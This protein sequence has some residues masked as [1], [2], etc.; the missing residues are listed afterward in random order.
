MG[1]GETQLASGTI[2]G[3]RVAEKG[4]VLNVNVP[5]AFLAAMQRAFWALNVSLW[6]KRFLK[7]LRASVCG[8]HPLVSATK[9][10]KSRD[11]IVIAICVSN[12]ASQSSSDLRHV[13]HP[14]K[15]QCGDLMH[16]DGRC[17]CDPK[18]V[19]TESSNHKWRGSDLQFD[20]YRTAVQR[21]FL[22]VGLRNFK[23]LAIGNL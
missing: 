16:R 17:E 11:L 10:S 9:C 20:P 23:S 21:N 5:L 3:Q 8:I 4:Y 22:R 13:N 15:A 1:Q 19:R 7:S 12:R 6:V 2:R 18:V 14:R